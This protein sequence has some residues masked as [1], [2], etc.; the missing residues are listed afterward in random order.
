[1]VNDPG[2]FQLGLVA[3]LTDYTVEGNGITGDGLGSHAVVTGGTVSG[4]GAVDHDGA[5]TVGDVHITVGAVVN[6]GDDTGD[7]VL[8]GSVRIVG[9]LLSD[10]NCFGNAQVRIG[11]RIGR[12]VGRR[13]VD[14]TGQHTAGTELNGA[15]IVG[16]HTINGNHVIDVQLFSTVTLQSVALDGI[17]VAVHSD[18][19]VAIGITVGIING[20]DRAGQGACVR[21]RLAGGQCIGGLQNLHGI[22]GSNGNFSAA[23]FHSF[24]DTALGKLDFTV[25]V[26]QRTGNCNCVTHSQLIGTVTLQTVALDGHILSAGDLD[27]NRDILI[28]GIIHGVDCENDTCQRMGALEGLAGLE[29][30]GSLDDFHGFFINSGRDHMI[31]ADAQLT[32]VLAGD[33]SCQNIGC[34]LRALFGNLFVNVN[35]VGVVFIL[36]Y[37]N[38]IFPY[39]HGPGDIITGG[40]DADGA[41][42]GI[43]HG[44]LFR[45]LFIECPQILDGLLQLQVGLDFFLS[46]FCRNALFRFLGL[47]RSFLGASAKQAQA[48]SQYQ[49]QCKNFLHNIR[50]FQISGL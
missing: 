15:I 28:G 13:V 30:I 19:D 50:P 33:D 49:E 24:Q 22:F 43:V 23:A 35:R 21:Q 29:G 31:P 38:D 39:V 9:F 47:D 26:G 2:I 5:G 40:A 7:I 32:T 36:N 10:S 12:F 46:R 16:K 34:R 37:R 48:H 14:Q 44:C 41:Q 11:S 3:I 27:G 1:M 17:A 6:L 45:S 18:R 25:V 42:T 4:P 20:S 8:A